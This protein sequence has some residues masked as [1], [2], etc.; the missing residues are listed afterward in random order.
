MSKFWLFA[1]VRSKLPWA[2]KYYYFKGEI[3]FLWLPW[4]KTTQKLYS[5]T[6]VNDIVDERQQFAGLWRKVF[7]KPKNSSTASRFEN[8]KSFWY[9]FLFLMACSSKWYTACI[10]G[11]KI[12]F[13]LFSNFYLLIRLKNPKNF[14]LNPAIF[15][16][17][18][19]WMISIKMLLNVIPTILSSQ[20][21]QK[22]PKKNRFCSGRL[23]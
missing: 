11:C 22:T 18:A 6:S 10:C 2:K 12:S 20:E 9:T 1:R 16:Q 7:P 4:C 14:F 23:C 19:N 17:N 3:D 13:F 15:L 5:N 8:E 21:I